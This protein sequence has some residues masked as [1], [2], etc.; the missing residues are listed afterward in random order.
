[1]F[2]PDPG[3]RFLS[4]PDPRSRIQDPKTATKKMGDGFG[5][6]GIRDGKI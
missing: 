5:E 2:I 1:M 4:I 6:G 3:S